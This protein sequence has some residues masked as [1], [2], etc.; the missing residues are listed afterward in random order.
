MVSFLMKPKILR[1]NKF[2]MTLIAMILSYFPFSIL[3]GLPPSLSESLMLSMSVF[4]VI[5]VLIIVL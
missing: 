2:L 3:L 5:N 4:T 1:G